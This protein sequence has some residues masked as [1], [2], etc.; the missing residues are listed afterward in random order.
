MTSTGPPRENLNTGDI[1]HWHLLKLKELQKEL[2]GRQ[3]S[4]VLRCQD[5]GALESRE[6]S[7]WEEGEPL[8]LHASIPGTRTPVVITVSDD[9]YL[10]KR[11][12]GAEMACPVY[13]F[14][15]AL[16]LIIYTVNV[17]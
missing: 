17:S 8:E 15:R 16:E 3:V 13:L 1:R 4:A 9:C 5:L 14:S 11:A 2:K 12:D 7:A 10:W 6:V